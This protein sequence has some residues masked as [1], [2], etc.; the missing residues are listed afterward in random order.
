MPPGTPGPETRERGPRAF[1][2]WTFV[3]PSQPRCRKGLGFTLSQLGQARRG[4]WC[5]VGVKTGLYIPTGLGFGGFSFF[6]P[7]A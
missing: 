3:R 4:S 7:P 6:L 1:A 5:E 2:S